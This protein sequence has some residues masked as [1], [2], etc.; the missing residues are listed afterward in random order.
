VKLPEDLVRWLQ[1]NFADAAAAAQI[2]ESAV[3][4]EGKPASAR[5]LRCAALGSRG[6][7][8]QLRQLVELTKIDYRDVIVAGEYEVRG[9]EWI[10]L[11]DLNQPIP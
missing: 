2:L 4:H 11:R 10:R 5:L 9:S 1:A 8:E 7:I 3:D 6:E